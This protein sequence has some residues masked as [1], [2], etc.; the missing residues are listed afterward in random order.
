MP[1]VWTLAQRG[2]SRPAPACSRVSP[3]RP[4]RRLRKSVATG[5]T[6]AVDLGVEAA[7]SKRLTL[8][9]VGDMTG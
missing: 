6:M 8:T 1:K 3:A 4:S 7:S 9:A 2:I 5:T